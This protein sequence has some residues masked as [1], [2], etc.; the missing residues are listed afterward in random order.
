MSRVQKK[1]CSDTCSKI[2]AHAQLWEAS[3]E[4]LALFQSKNLVVIGY[5][6]LRTV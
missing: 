4:P 1:I 6:G 5:G 3:L 2:I